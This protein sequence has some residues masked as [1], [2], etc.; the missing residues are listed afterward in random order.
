MVAEEGKPQNFPRSLLLRLGEVRMA[1]RYS[2]NPLRRT[3]AVGP[4]R[5]R[6]PVT[7]PASA[8]WAAAMQRPGTAA[9]SGGGFLARRR[10]QDRERDAVHKGAAADAPQP[11]SP[12]PPGLFL[13]EVHRK[14]KV[15]FPGVGASMGTDENDQ[16]INLHSF[17]FHCRRRSAWTPSFLYGSASADTWQKALIDPQQVGMLEGWLTLRQ[18]PSDFFE[19]PTRLPRPSRGADSSA[20][21][22]A[23]QASAATDPIH[24]RLRDAQGE[25]HASPQEFLPKHAVLPNYMLVRAAKTGSARPDSAASAPIRWPLPPKPS[26]V[27]REDAELARTYGARYPRTHK[28]R[29]AAVDPLNSVAATTV[30]EA[31][32]VQGCWED[33]AAA[34]SHQQGDMSALPEELQLALLT[35]PGRAPRVYSHADESWG[36]EDQNA[37]PS[38]ALRAQDRD[39]AAASDCILGRRHR[40]CSGAT[41][42]VTS[43]GVDLKYAKECS[44]ALPSSSELLPPPV[45]PHLKTSLTPRQ[46]RA[47]GQSAHSLRKI[48]V[49]GRSPRRNARD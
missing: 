37:W 27:Y 28:H 39:N 31:G 3:R 1:S 11:S 10:R 30:S 14:N 26:G 9:T 43:P 7:L 40:T 29:V 13:R 24:G 32:V 20:Q 36:G 17:L 19:Q 23:T 12:H 22:P 35:A 16:P 38:H 15:L 34:A 25:H 49:F 18:A 6:L 48:L 2:F 5:A 47:L 33:A 44:R 21:R 4:A 46:R 8:T 45:Q 41:A 42:A